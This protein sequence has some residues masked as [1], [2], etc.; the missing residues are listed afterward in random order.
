MKSRG[1]GGGGGFAGLLEKGTKWQVR[2]GAAQ[3]VL[4]RSRPHRDEGVAAAVGAGPLDAAQ[5][6]GGVG[7]VHQRAVDVAE[8]DAARHCSAGGCAVPAAGGGGGGPCEQRRETQLRGAS[9]DG[10][11]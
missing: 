9:G 5:L 6:V 7:V 10:P 11:G 3:A 1:G 2:R 4:A 8:E